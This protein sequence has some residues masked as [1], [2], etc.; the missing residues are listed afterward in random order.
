[1]R[2]PPENRVHEFI[3]QPRRGLWRLALPMIAGMSVHTIYMIVDFAFIG[4]ISDH[5][6]AGITLVGPFFFVIIALLNGMATAFTALISQAL[7][8]RDEAEAGRVASASLG[9]AFGLGLVFLTIGALLGRRLLQAAGAD[10]EVLDLAWAYFQVVVFTVPLFFVSGALRSVLTGEGDATTPL[11]IMGL[12]TVLNLGLDWLFI[13]GL[14]W[15][16]RGAALATAAAQVFSLI[17]F[18]VRVFIQRRTVARFRLRHAVPHRAMWR[19]LWIIGLPSAV[20]QLVMAAGSAA[21]IRLLAEFGWLTVAGYGAAS[22]VDMIV[23]MPIIGLA[24][25]AVTLLGMFAGSGRPDL[26]RSTALYAYRWGVTL[27]VVVGVAAF[28][29][30]GW[31]MRLFVDKPGSIDVGRTYLTYMLAMYPMMAFGMTT[32]RLL[33]GLGY[34]FP[35]LMITFVRVIAVS[36]PMAYVAVYV[37][38][39][40]VQSVWISILVGAATSNVLSFLWVRRLVWRADPTR[41]ARAAGT[42]AE[43]VSVPVD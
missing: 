7:G 29:C 18:G 33:Q 36:V 1:M 24:G 28:L 5:A 41:R 10:G 17:L 14:G 15:G 6:V 26:V 2:K 37:F 31:V 3:A 8:R 19:G 4:T 16:T 21:F 32:G 34:G 11:V 23:R 42:P 9:F 25:A 30:S 39:A 40:P 20:G 27:A 43:A 38:D 22:R 13:V 35:S 12:S